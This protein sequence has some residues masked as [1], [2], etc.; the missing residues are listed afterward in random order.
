MLGEVQG[1]L[2]SEKLNDAAIKAELNA[3]A[4]LREPIQ[5][6]KLSLVSEVARVQGITHRGCQTQFH[7][8]RQQIWP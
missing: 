2:F 4:G 7:D 6:D 1:L 3:D 8:Q 5:F